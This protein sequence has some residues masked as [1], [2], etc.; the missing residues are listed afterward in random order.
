M[1]TEGS[2]KYSS[3]FGAPCGGW[4]RGLGQLPSFCRM[5]GY[6]VVPSAEK[7][8]ILPE[9]KLRSCVLC[10]VTPSVQ[11]SDSSVPRTGNY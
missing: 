8:E 2:R 1:G 6:L 10:S 5:T 7:E 3:D 9:Y 11:H 4:K